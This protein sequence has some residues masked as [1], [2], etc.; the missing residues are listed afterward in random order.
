[1]GTPGANSIPPPATIDGPHFLRALWLFGNTA[2]LIFV[3]DL[4]SPIEPRPLER[5]D[6]QCVSDLHPALVPV[7]RRHEKREI[8]DFASGGVK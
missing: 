2:D 3:I 4:P 8:A 7:E 6:Q 5:L 1:M